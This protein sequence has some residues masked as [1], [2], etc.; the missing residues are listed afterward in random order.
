MEQEFK[1]A[2]VLQAC[3]RK[4]KLMDLRSLQYNSYYMADPE[5]PILKALGENNIERIVCGS[6]CTVEMIKAIAK[7]DS[8][9]FLSL[10]VV[11]SI[12]EPFQKYLQ[13]TK[14]LCYL[15]ID[16]SSTYDLLH[17]QFIFEE[18]YDL[19]TLF[20]ITIDCNLA[21]VVELVSQLIH[22]NQSLIWLD[23]G[24]EFQD[25]DTSP[26]AE[27]IA[28]SRTLRHLTLT[29]CFLGVHEL[30]ILIDSLKENQSLLEFD[31]YSCDIDFHELQFTDDWTNPLSKVLESCRTLENFGLVQDNDEFRIVKNVTKIIKKCPNLGNPNMIIDAKVTGNPLPALTRA[32]LDNRN[33]QKENTQKAKGLVKMAR[34]LLLL[35]TN[36][37]FELVVMIFQQQLP[38][39]CNSK[40]QEL[41]SDVLMSRDTI[42]LQLPF[43]FSYLELLRFA[44]NRVSLDQDL[45]QLIEEARNSQYA[46]NELRQLKDPYFINTDFADSD[47]Y[48]SDSNTHQSDEDEED[49]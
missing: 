22:V 33:I 37:P 34:N 26:L 49:F 45:L 40:E 3:R 9:L 16:F 29:E 32:Y 25:I 36:L 38:N 14:R 12:V 6:N 46:P 17:I 43:Q 41:I 44:H 13:E 27:A 42:G 35:K 8:C 1:Y 30:W 5:S 15:S 31:L 47:Y 48:N 20:G 23:Y 11:P 39:S 18:L 24:T 2:K 28:N 7:R 4:D 10:R 19:R 21:K